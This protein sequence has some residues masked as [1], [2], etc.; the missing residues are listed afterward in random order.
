MIS[1]QAQG[2]FEKVQTVQASQPPGPNLAEQ[3]HRQAA[4]LAGYRFARWQSKLGGPHGMSW[5]YCQRIT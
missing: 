4:S 5:E 2:S 1:M 3:D